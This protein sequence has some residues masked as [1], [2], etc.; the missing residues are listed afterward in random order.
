MVRV[1]VANSNKGFIKA[2]L[3]HVFLG[4]ADYCDVDS[5]FSTNEL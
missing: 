4:G 1:V 5:S 3:H 2:E